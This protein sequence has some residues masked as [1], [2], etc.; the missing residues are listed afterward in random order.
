MCLP[1]LYLLKCEA[2][3]NSQEGLQ[4]IPEFWISDS[5]YEYWLLVLAI[6]KVIYPPKVQY[7]SVCG[8]ERGPEESLMHSRTEGQVHARASYDMQAYAQIQTNKTSIHPILD[9]TVIHFDIL[10]SP[11]GESLFAIVHSSYI[12]TGILFHERVT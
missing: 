10:V 9:I 7:G 5:P 2:Y 8:P 3:P 11:V 4:G 1:L 12:V 6:D